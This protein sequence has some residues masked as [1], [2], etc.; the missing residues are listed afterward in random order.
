MLEVFAGNKDPETYLEIINSIFK[1]YVA[2]ELPQVYNEF[3]QN[4]GVRVVEKTFSGLK[5]KHDD[6]V[7]ALIQHV[8]GVPYNDLS[9]K[10]VI[11][12]I[13]KIEEAVK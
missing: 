8:T 12:T 4:I 1:D 7:A 11:E 9:P 2:A 5:T 3:T 10:K 13:E 6:N